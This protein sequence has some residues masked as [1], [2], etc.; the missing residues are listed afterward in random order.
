[1]NAKG[2][3]STDREMK[4]DEISPRNSRHVMMNVVKSPHVGFCPV[5][6]MFT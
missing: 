5:H 2:V 4:C 6:N 3:L 1:M